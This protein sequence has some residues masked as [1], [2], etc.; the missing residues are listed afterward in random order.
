M[1]W[2]ITIKE[3]YIKKILNGTKLYEVRTKIPKE[4]RM[5]DR[6]FVCEPKTSGKVVAMFEVSGIYSY[7]KFG[8]WGLHR[9]WMGI[10]E[11][12]YFKYVQNKSIVHLIKVKNVKSI[13]KPHYITEFGLKKAPQWFAKVK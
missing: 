4:L 8:A 6:I 1:D 2:I 3:K 12:E 10:E 11:K 13:E 9:F 7:A 5:D